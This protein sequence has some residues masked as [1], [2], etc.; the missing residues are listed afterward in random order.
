[1]LHK[2]PKLWLKPKKP[3]KSIIVNFFWIKI[4]L[5]KK[6]H[7]STQFSK[8]SKPSVHFCNFGSLSKIK[9]TYFGHCHLL[10]IK[11]NMSIN[12]LNY[13]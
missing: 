8:I 13:S 4:S 10:G 6:W 12:A 7:G 11:V 5:F 9:N 1:M 3:N 2:L